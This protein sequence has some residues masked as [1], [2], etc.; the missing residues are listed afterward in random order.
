MTGDAELLIYEK[1]DGVAWLTFNRPGA[2]NAINLALRDQLWDALEAVS[3]DPDVGVVVFRGAGDRAFSSGA[4][5]SDF[6]TAPSYIEARRG[7]LERDIWGRLADFPKPTIAAIHGYALGA[8]C[9]L[10]LLCDLRIASDD[11]QFG[12]PEVGLGYIPTAGGSQ[13]LSRTVGLGHA[14]DMILTG[15]RI[16]AATALDYGLVQWVVPRAHLYSRAEALAQQLLAAPAG[17][18]QA[19]REALRGAMDLTL[20]EGLKLEARLN[21]RL[22]SV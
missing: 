17:A 9:E 16:N 18:V 10:S 2:L 4:D 21:G 6:G 8:G 14:L 5:I 1:R 7:R 19:A 20:S 12:L 13:T 3:L 22:A 15:D 11:A